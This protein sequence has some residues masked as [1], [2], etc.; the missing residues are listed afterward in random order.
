MCGIAGLWAVTEPGKRESQV[1]TMCARMASRGPDGDGFWHDESAGLTLGFR[2]LSIIDLNKRSDQ[3]MLSESGRFAIVF[4]GEI[5]NYREIRVELEARKVIFRTT[6]DTEVLLELLARDG[7]NAVH[8]LRGMFAFALWDRVARVLYLARDPYG[9]KPLYIADIGNGIAFSSQVKALAASGCSGA[10]SP[11]ALAAFFLTGSIPEPLTLFRNI[12]SVPA[13]AVVT[14]SD[15]KVGQPQIYGDISEAWTQQAE[16]QTPKEIAEQMR[17]AIGD[18]IRHHLVADVPIS[19]FLSGGADSGVIAGIAKGEAK[20]LE[21]ITVGF[22]EFDG[23]NE[24]EVPR[25]SRIAKQYGLM[26]SMRFINRSEFEADLP[27]ILDAMDQPTIDGVNTWFAS[28]A[29]AERG[30]KVALSGLGGDE[31]F[32]GYSTFR[33]VPRLLNLSRLSSHLPSALTRAAFSA[34]AYAFKKPKLVAIPDLAITQTGAHFLFRSL[35][36]AD[37]LQYLLRSDIVRESLTSLGNYLL[38]GSQPDGPNYLATIAR[39]ESVRYLRNQLLRDSDWASMA[40]SLELRTP[41]VDIKLLR[42]MAPYIMSFCDGAGKKLLA[43]LPK[44]GLPK[45]VLNHSKTGFSLPLGKWI[46]ESSLTQEWR[47]V[48]PLTHRSTS[49]ARRWAYIVA[50]HFAPELTA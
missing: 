18:S 32:C 5:Y 1:R 20:I 2:R 8:R 28:K 36:M 30:Y 6:S 10:K 26:H 16:G 33:V 7:I 50:R 37:D 44:E 27:L 49:W 21:G 46:T 39:L 38:D 43:S 17:A 35:F 45:G 12:C 48:G 25:A 34:A 29:A 31:L 3:P 22:Q 9:I 14:I 24:N 4:N 40:H 23:Q 42:T 15:R 19:I 41:Y 11:G 47:G 13:G